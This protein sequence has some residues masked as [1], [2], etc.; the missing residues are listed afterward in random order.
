MKGMPMGETDRYRIDRVY[1]PSLENN[2]LNSPVERDLHVYLPPDYFTSDSQCY[3]V[4]YCLHGYGQ[5]SQS[6]TVTATLEEKFPMEIYPPDVQK[7]LALEHIATYRK[8]DAL[9]R[10]GECAP[11]IF[12]QPD[13]SLY[14]PN[15]CGLTDE[16]GAALPK[17]SFF[18]NAPS[19]GNYQGYIA[20]DVPTYMDAQYRTRPEKRHRALMGVSMG[21]YG[22]LHICLHHPDQFGAAVALSPGQLSL[23][24]F[25]VN[26][27]TPLYELLL[28]RDAAEQLCTAFL[29]DMLDTGDLIYSPETPLL[30][31]IQRD[32]T[33][34]LVDWN[35][36]ARAN[37]EQ[38]DLNAWVRKTPQALKEIAL[39]L[40][41]EQN[42]E[43]GFAQY[44]SSVHA[45][46]TE[47]G[48]PHQFDL[49][50][51]PKAALAPH[52]L[53]CVYNVLTGI[54]FCLQHI[55]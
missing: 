8:F 34:K 25:E 53:G 44:A 29:N 45:T 40:I 13:G 20:N 27:Y 26:F 46:L 37:W 55:I 54:R 21:G 41:C 49:Y 30:P 52:F 5:D 22:T 50:S 1:A 16:S 24:L 12:V 10:A 18:L 43:L 51:D 48:I 38:Y 7:Q 6:I 3:P 35:P 28:G 36:D 19:I 42:D 39:M 31:S 4:I 14:V 33:G 47:L 17:G 23:D 32:P 2:P 15:V 9:I 11:F